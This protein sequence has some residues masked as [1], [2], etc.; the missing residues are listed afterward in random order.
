MPARGITDRKEITV[1]MQALVSVSRMPNHVNA[2]L[3][4]VSNRTCKTAMTTADSAARPSVDRTADDREAVR[5]KYLE[6]RDKRLRPDGNEQYLRIAGQL[7]QYL[8]D[9]YTAVAER[10]PKTDHVTFAFIGGGFAGLVTGARLVE[11]G[12]ADVRI[13][14]KGGDFGGTWY[15][16]RYPGAQCDIE[17]YIYMPLLEEMG[18]MPKEKYSFGDEILDYTKRLAQTFDLYRDACFQT[19]VTD[20]RWEDATGHWVITTDRGDEMRARFV[21]LSTGVLNRPKLPALEGIEAFKGHSFHTSRWDYAYTGGGPNGDLTAL[22][23]KRVGIIGTGASA[24]QSVP[25]LGESAQHLFVFQ[26][27]PSSVDVRGNKPTDA[28]WAKS[29][30][31]GWQQERITNFN[32]LVGGGFQQVDLVD[33]GW[34]DIITRL[35]TFLPREGGEISPEEAAQASEFA[36]FEKMES[37]RARVDAIVDNKQTAE[38]LKPYYRQ[39]CKRPCFHD[40]YLPTYN[41]PN[42]TLVDT[43]GKGVARITETGVTVGDTTYEVDCLIFAS[44]FEV[45]TSL[46]RRSGFETVG[47]DGTTITEKWADG[48]K[49]FHG[50]LSRGFPNCFFMGLTQTGLTPN[51]TLMLN[52]QAQHIAYLINQTTSR[53]STVIEASQQAEDDWQDEMR[54]MAMFAKDFFEACTPGYY[55]NDGHV[56][57][58]S[59]LI[60]TA[61]GGGSEAFFKIIR[62]WREGGQLD[63]LELS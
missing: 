56:S 15:W 36:D 54:R 24:I 7:T 3:A 5:R 48:P 19:G 37:I 16:N 8:E 10:A 23:D 42:V 61:Y 51:F 57:D 28:S 12:V 18:Y 33:D 45:G 63:G 20:T 25:H 13:I 34:T 9:P 55:N 17:S 4:A 11:A 53:A 21:V 50:F 43:D 22:R 58:N 62:D 52:E 26:R 31:A 38:A 35:A 40:E 39:F 14:E 32:V 6:E 60:A 41:R 29:L 27:T 59:G 44:G 47:R 46:A 2:R 49:T 30:H 1:R